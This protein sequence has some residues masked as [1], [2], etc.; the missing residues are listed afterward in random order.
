MQL[1]TSFTLMPGESRG[2]GRDSSSLGQIKHAKSV[3]RAGT[4]RTSFPAQK[5]GE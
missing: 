3:F 1:P 5:E 4:K 2:E